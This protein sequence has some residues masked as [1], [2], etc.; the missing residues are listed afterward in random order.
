MISRFQEENLDLGEGLVDKVLDVV[1]SCGEPPVIRN[2][3][4]KIASAL[5]SASRIASCSDWISVDLDI[6]IQCWCHAGILANFN[7]E[8]V[9]L[10]FGG[11]GRLRS[12]RP[13]CERRSQITNGVRKIEKF[14]AENRSQLFSKCVPAVEKD[15]SCQANEFSTRKCAKRTLTARFF[16]VAN[17]VRKIT[18]GVR[19][20][21]T[22]PPYTPFSPQLK[23]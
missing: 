15:C 12:Q 20:L 11:G 9:P 18:N 10:A 22:K 6:V 3:K 7:G 13:F 17:G 19:K 1:A 16:F 14:L 21:R 23:K 5:A 4:L 8:R 2:E